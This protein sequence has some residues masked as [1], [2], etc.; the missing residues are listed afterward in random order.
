MTVEAADM[1]SLQVRSGQGA[2]L[3]I[4]APGRVWNGGL[5]ATVFP[6]RSLRWSSLASLHSFW[7]RFGMTSE[8][9]QEIDREEDGKD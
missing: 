7:P 3:W 1:A 4:S 9:D 2:K 5:R 8:M 6:L